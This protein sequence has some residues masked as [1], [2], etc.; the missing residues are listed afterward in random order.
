MLMSSSIIKVTHGWFRCGEGGTL[1]RGEQGQ[2]GASWNEEVDSQHGTGVD[3]SFI[4]GQRATTPS[5]RFYLYHICVEYCCLCC[6]NAFCAINIFLLCRLKKNH[7]M[8]L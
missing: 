1:G 5:K 6:M 4:L 3:G 7:M 8:N 2:D